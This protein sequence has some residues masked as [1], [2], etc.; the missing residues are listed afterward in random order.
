MPT[1]EYRCKSCGHEFEIN[2]R[3]SDDALTDCPKCN[4]AELE[5]LISRTSFQL[6]GTGWY[7]TDFKNPPAKTEAKTETKAETKTE[8][9][10][11]T[12]AK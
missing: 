7:A 2:Q 12:E 4:Q 10:S 9:K 3:M 8:T 1:Y 11:T 6:K 5:K